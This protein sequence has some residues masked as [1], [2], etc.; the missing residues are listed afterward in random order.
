MIIT[1]KYVIKCLECLSYNKYFNGLDFGVIQQAKYYNSRE[2]AKNTILTNKE[3]YRGNY[4]IEE[5]FYKN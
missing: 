4:I 2:I 5:V 3:L 1:I